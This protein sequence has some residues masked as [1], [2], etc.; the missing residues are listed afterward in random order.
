VA[1]AVQEQALTHLGAQQLV[2]DKMLVEL[3]IMLAVVVVVT[4]LL[5]V[6]AAVVQ[7]VTFL[8]HLQQM[9]LLEPLI[10]AVEAVVLVIEVVQMV[11]K[12]VVQA[13]QEL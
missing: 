6:M 3:I 12:M 1:L 9:V 13:A 7:E 8:R 2:Q 11:L 4:P 10:Q 5:V